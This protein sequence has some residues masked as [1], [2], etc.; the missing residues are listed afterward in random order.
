MSSFAELF[1]CSQFVK[2]NPRKPP[3]VTCTRNDPNVRHFKE[4]EEGGDVDRDARPRF[5]GLKQ[6][7]PEKYYGNGCEYVRV[8][9]HEGPFGQPVIEDAQLRVFEGNALRLLF[10]VLGVK[11][12]GTQAKNSLLNA[13]F[14]TRKP[15]VHVVDIYGGHHEPLLPPSTRV[16]VMGRVREKGKEGYGVEVAGIMGFVAN[17]DI[18][19]TFFNLTEG[20]LQRFWVKS[21]VVDRYTP[22][23]K[24]TL[25]MKQQ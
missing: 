15:I 5:F 8:L 25:S 19:G 6:D 17:A 21:L 3:I 22:A 16:Q 14:R 7:M 13:V 23:I 18:A 24:M 10:Q 11:N 12:D 1:R 2:F 4:V 9:K 20:S